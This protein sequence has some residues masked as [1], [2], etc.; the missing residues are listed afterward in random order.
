MSTLQYRHEATPRCGAIHRGH[1]PALQV[2]SLPNIVHQLCLTLSFTARLNIKLPI[3]P[4]FYTF[5]QYSWVN[6][7]YSYD[8]IS[9]HSSRFLSDSA[10]GAWRHVVRKIIK[11]PKIKLGGVRKEFPFLPHLIP[12]SNIF[13]P[14]HT[15]CLHMLPWH[16]ALTTVISWYGMQPKV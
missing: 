10:G 11:E 3:M 16:N 2:H 15:P 6:N 13:A 14:F 7:D 12:A 1:S 5:I 9:L 8:T 4:L